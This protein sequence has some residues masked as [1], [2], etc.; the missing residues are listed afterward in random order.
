MTRFFQFSGVIL[1]LLFSISLP[2]SAQG[3][4][5]DFVYE[6]E[7]NSVI[8]GV[9]QSAWSK[10]SLT[11][12]ASVTSVGEDAFWGC[13]RLQELYIEGNPY[14]EEGAFNDE[15]VG[16]LSY[17]NTGSGMEADNILRMVTQLGEGH[18]VETIDIEG[19]P[20]AESKVINWNRAAH[21]A[22]FT[23]D[24]EVRLPAALVST[25]VFGDAQ[26]MGKF[27]LTGDLGTFCA[28][29]NFEEVSNDS[30]FLFY[31]PTELRTDAATG[32][33]QVFIERVRFVVAGQGVLMHRLENTSEEIYLRRVDE[34]SPYP[35]NM[36]VG[37]TKPT[38]IGKTDGDKTN[39]ILYQG[40]FH[41]TSGGTLGAN[42]AYLQLPTES[43]WPENRSTQAAL[44]Y[45]IDD[46]TTDG[47]ATLHIAPA[48]AGDDTW[49]SVGGQRLPA[50]PTQPG[51]YVHG[52]RLQVVK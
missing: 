24:M 25:Q 33:Q 44:S 16:T 28:K 32:E 27:T 43:L 4:A 6:D 37:V 19:Y 23:S 21:T 1:S 31:V 49:Y 41:P 22:V 14:F 7:T 48:Q 39:L 13:T 51:V 35:T 5:D 45:F 47:I 17:L 42:R 8:T 52:K 30:Q 34:A 38:T 3:S 9:N 40:K 2:A 10:T 12:P 26:V 15:V 50:R 46:S 29:A 36:L 18:N 11:I 20:D